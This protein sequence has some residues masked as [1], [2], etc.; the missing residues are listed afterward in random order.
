MSVMAFMSPTKEPT[1]SALKVREAILHV[2]NLADAAACEVTQLD[3]IKTLFL[4]DKAHLNDYGR[5]VTFDKYVAMQNGPVASLAYDI[6]KGRKED[7]S[8]AGIV[9][10]L[11][12]VISS[13]KSGAK[14]YYA[15]V[16]PASQDIL[17]Q[18]DLEA[19]T[20]AFDQFCKLGRSAI[21]DLV[22]RDPA[23][24]DAWAGRGEAKQAPIRLSLM[25]N[26]PDEERAQQVKYIAAHL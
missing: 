23:W 9:D 7:L 21:L 4:A 17:S 12:S 20:E 26:P 10:P 2:L 19:L 5:P 3:I 13:D 11:W 16:R 25:F 1:R 8:K 24:L 15:P 22:H 6:L 14:V 18:S